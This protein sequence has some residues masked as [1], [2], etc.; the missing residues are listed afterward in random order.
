MIFPIDRKKIFISGST[1]KIQK[2]EVATKLTGRHITLELFPLSFREF[3]VFKGID[4]DKL[5]KKDVLTPTEESTLR[6]SL[7]E[8][9]EFGRYTEVT[10]ERN[11]KMKIAILS[12]Y[13][14]DLLYRD[15]IIRY[16]IRESQP[17]EIFF[18]RIISNI[19]KY[20]SYNRIKN[21][22]RNMNISISID[23]IYR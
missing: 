18:K 20:F 13:Y 19:S 3:L 11:P 6:G 17:L 15:I 1:S 21:I 9:M 8:Y 12:N 22:M 23:T 2:P 7:Q 10:L 16:G 5:T 14:N 4:I